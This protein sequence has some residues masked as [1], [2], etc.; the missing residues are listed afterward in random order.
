MGIL[1]S[2]LGLLPLLIHG[3]ESLHGPGNGE[4]KKVTVI[5]AVFEAAGAL[6]PA[7]AAEEVHNGLSKAIDG[8]VAVMNALGALLNPAAKANP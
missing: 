6:I 5:K 8:I 1:T 2:I 7:N 3:A 4:S